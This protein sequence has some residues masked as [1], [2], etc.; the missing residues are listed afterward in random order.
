MWDEFFEKTAT[1]PLWLKL[2]GIIATLIAADIILFLSLP[3]LRDIPILAIIVI[4]GGYFYSGFVISKPPV[5]TYFLILLALFAIPGLFINKIAGEE[6]SSLRFVLQLVFS[7]SVLFIP[8]KQ[9]VDIDIKFLLKFLNIVGWI[10]VVS[11]IL[12]LL[13]Y[14]KTSAAIHE[15]A[16]IMPLFLIPALYSKK[17]NYILI[18]LFFAAIIFLINPRTTMFLVYLITFFFPIILLTIRIVRIKTILIISALT[19]FF[20]LIFL[21]QILGFISEIDKIFKTSFG[22]NSNASFRQYLIVVGIVEFFKSPIYGKY[23]SGSNGYSTKFEHGKELPLH[24]DLLEIAV[25][26]GIIG[27][28]LFLSGII[29]IFFTLNKI[30]YQRHNELTNPLRILIITVATSLVTGLI[31]IAFNPIVNSTHTGFFFFFI[32]GLSILL[33]RF[34]RLTKSESGLLM[35]DPNTSQIK[36]YI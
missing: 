33:I 31:T 11:R 23:F 1:W 18:T 22:R 12:V 14:P 27:V 17:I 26:G 2:S 13:L 28:L 30:L 3:I 4:L 20:V 5:A 8:S 6:T 10:F 7:L 16:F 15:L 34:V 29:G 25:Q 32:L 36:G 9:I 35:A 19:L 24:N 21:S